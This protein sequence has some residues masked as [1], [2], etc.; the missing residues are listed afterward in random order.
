MKRTVLAFII[1]WVCIS[2][3]NAQ[4]LSG[5][6]ID[7][8]IPVVVYVNGKQVSDAVQSCF[9]AGLRRG[10]YF[11]EAFPGIRSEHDRRPQKPL[12][13]KRVDYSGSDI[14]LIRIEG[15]YRPIPDQ[16]Y[17]PIGMDP[18][19]FEGLQE[20]VKK[21]NFDSDKLD[22]FKKLPKNLRLSAK[23]ISLLAGS[24]SFDSSKENAVK[25]LYPRCV[26]KENFFTILNIFDF[27]SSRKR[28]IE[29]MEK[30]H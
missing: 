7:S 23:Q 29:I 19:A 4:Q 16:P 24:C 2:F 25:A 9:I 13:S 14:L 1:M 30:M 5:I 20:L 27:D 26:D 15:D 17:Y 28:M 21:I 12:L 22:L 10:N 3:C 18:E 6:R 8:P 11:I